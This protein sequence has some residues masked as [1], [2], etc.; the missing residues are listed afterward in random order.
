MHSDARYTL[1]LTRA[2]LWSLHSTPKLACAR[3]ILSTRTNPGD[4]RRRP[5]SS[6]CA[7]PSDWALGG[8]KPEKP[9]LA[10]TVNEDSL[11]FNFAVFSPHVR[12]TCIAFAVLS[13]CGERDGGGRGA[14]EG[15]GG[16]APLE[17]A[18]RGGH[19]EGGGGGRPGGGGAAR[20]AQRH[21]APLPA[22]VPRIHAQAVRAPSRVRR[23][24]LKP[25]P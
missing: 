9:G 23:S 22:P 25:G 20:G 14:C 8:S 6:G 18:Q 1:G 17:G 3:P 15:A 5:G 11:S 24:H 21:A 12:R 4:T 10:N 2:I 7:H 19:H 13:T 16:A